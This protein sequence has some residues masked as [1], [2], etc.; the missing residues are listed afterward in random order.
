MLQPNNFLLINA[1][2]AFSIYDENYFAISSFNKQ[3]AKMQKNSPPKSFLLI[4]FRSGEEWPNFLQDALPSFVKLDIVKEEDA[5]NI[6]SSHSYDLLII[7]ASA[8]YDATEL[9]RNLH[10]E[11]NIPILVVTASPT[12]QS[13]REILKAGA[14][15]YIGRSFDKKELR[16]R[17][18]NTLKITS[19]LP[20]EKKL[21]KEKRK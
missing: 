2:N 17:I 10:L 19:F 11:Q 4:G 14:V 13:A 15:D 20:G 12:W 1:I 5:R 8:V 21:D 3:K 16:L 9:V 7:D 18:N 6:I